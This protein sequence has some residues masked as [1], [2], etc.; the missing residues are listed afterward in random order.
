MYM[1]V[2]SENKNHTYKHK[3]FIHAVQHDISKSILI[4]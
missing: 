4:S 3:R 2:F 1:Y